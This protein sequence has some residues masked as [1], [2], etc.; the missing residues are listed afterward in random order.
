MTYF[1][2]SLVSV[3]L[4]PNL[5][6]GRKIKNKINFDITACDVC[7]RAKQTGNVF[8]LSEN[9]TNSLFELIH[10][11]VWDTYHQNRAVILIIF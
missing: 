3:I 5:R 9:K 2:A 7:H 4:R 6:G 11:D 8:P 10:C 1:K